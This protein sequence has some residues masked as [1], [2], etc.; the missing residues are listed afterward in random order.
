MPESATAADD[1]TAVRWRAM[2]R[3][4]L[5]CLLPWSCVSCGRES[6][7]IVCPGCREHVGWIDGPCC[8]R[9]G[10]PLASGPDHL[11]GRCLVDPPSFRRLRAV[12][13]YRSSHEERDPIG[14]AV[15]ALKYGGRHALAAPL[16]ELFAER[17]PFSPGEYDRVAAVPLH[18]ERLRERG[19]NQ[20]LLLARAPASR[21]RAPLDPALL[22]RVRSTDPQV[23]LSEPERRRN[24]RG[25]FAVRPGRR[26]DDLRILLVDD[27]CTTT[28]TAEACARVLLASGA[29]VVDVAVVARTLLH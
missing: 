7:A 21:L 12:A 28:A 26:V 19:F 16:S 22:V 15:R 13:C 24:L 29:A 4:L 2:V 8:A 6:R 11:C 3:G 25:A 18:L 17:L 10:L 14:C 23:G 5:D 1:T 27:V 20:A 9:C